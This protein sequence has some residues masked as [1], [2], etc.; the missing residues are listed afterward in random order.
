MRVFVRLRVKCYMRACVYLRAH[1][2]GLSQ[3]ERSGFSVQM[4]I[5]PLALIH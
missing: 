3:P 2:S 4:G 1:N 5:V